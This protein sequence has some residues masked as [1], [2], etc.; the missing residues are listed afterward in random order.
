METTQQRT[1]QNWRPMV[2]QESLEAAELKVRR[3]FV[4]RRFCGG[5]VE[6]RVLVLVLQEHRPP[7]AAGLSEADDGSH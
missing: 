5:S 4:L 7:A 6:S 2:L 3:L 1:E